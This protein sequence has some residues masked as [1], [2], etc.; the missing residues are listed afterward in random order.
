M[1]KLD[2]LKVAYCWRIVMDELKPEQGRLEPVRGTPSL[3]AAL[4]RARI[5]SVERSDVLAELRGAE[6]ARLEILSDALKP[7]LEQIPEEV[8]L[9]D[10]GIVSG[11]HPRLF[12]DMIGF[13]EMGRDRRQY[14]FSQDTRHGRILILESERIDVMLDAITTYIARRLVEREKA[15]ASD[16]TIEEA[17]RAFMAQQ[18]LE[19]DQRVERLRV[20][21][22]AVR[23]VAEPGSPVKA[24]SLLRPRKRLR[25]HL[26][27]ALHFIIEY[28]GVVTLLVLLMSG[29]YFG[30]HYAMDKWV[31]PIAR[32]GPAD[33]HGS[34]PQANP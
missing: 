15:L 2:W 20:P 16:R 26:F 5:E 12:I 13:V 19:V 34:V 21:P 14:R 1:A 3:T 30:Y 9:F 24:P 22:A 17:A 18:S 28:L 25:H 29:G 32:S 6:M 23:R 11:E 10:Q 31:H 33:T 27:R 4:R 7:V 8:D